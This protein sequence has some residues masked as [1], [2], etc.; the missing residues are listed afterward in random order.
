[1]RQQ[2]FKRILR[3]IAGDILTFTKEFLVVEKRKVLCCFVRKITASLKNNKRWTG[4]CQSLPLWQ[5]WLQLQLGLLLCKL[6]E[7]PLLPC[8]NTVSDVR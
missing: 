4:V 1:M 6:K 3:P 8:I 2:R 7:G 5:E